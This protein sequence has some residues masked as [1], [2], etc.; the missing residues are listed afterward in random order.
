MATVVN[1]Y[2]SKSGEA[3]R[4]D[5]GTEITDVWTVLFDDPATADQVQAC[6]AAG[7][8]APGDAHATAT[9]AVV[10]ALSAQAKGGALYEVSVVYRSSVGGGTTETN[11]LNLPPEVRWS[12]VKVTEPID[13]ALDDNNQPT[14]PI[15]NTA[16]IP[17]E[18][19]SKEI[20]D[21]VLSVQWNI[22][23]DDFDVQMLVA[24]QDAVSSDGYLSAPGQAKIELFEA[25][26]VRSEPANYFAM[27]LQVRFRQGIPAQ[28]DGTGGPARAWWK[29]LLNQGKSYLDGSDI[30]EITDVNQVLVS[31]PRLLAEDGSLLPNGGT[32]VWLE[33]KM[34]PEL[35]FSLLGIPYP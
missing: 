26:Y 33:F 22:D 3:I 29:R 12:G 15:V 35:P 1:V 7:L 13:Y 8:P 19:V 9:Y 11:P 30:I 14:I 2:K 10:K 24:Y 25:I 27:N 6:N 34:F 20:T 23:E 18:G 28:D 5:T 17:F 32:P 4:K 21:P 31:E 16:T